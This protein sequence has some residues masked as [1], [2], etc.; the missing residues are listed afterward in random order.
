MR[1]AAESKAF[2]QLIIKHVIKLIFIVETEKGGKGKTVERQRERPR[3]RVRA[4]VG[5]GGSIGRKQTVRKYTC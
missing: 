5:S 4:L 3:E 2:I 1:T